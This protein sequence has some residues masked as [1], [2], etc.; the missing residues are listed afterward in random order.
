MGAAC[1]AANQTGAGTFVAQNSGRRRYHIW[2]R[3][4]ALDDGTG[5]EPSAGGGGSVFGAAGGVIS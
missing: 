5:G 4:S 1:Y 3:I 2:M